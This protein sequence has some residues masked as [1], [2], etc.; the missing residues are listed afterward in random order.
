MNLKINFLFSKGLL[1]KHH[2]SVA[3]TLLLSFP[4][5]YSFLRE[6][7]RRYNKYNVV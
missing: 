7:H 4:V 3:F 5:V 2:T 6:N 1:T